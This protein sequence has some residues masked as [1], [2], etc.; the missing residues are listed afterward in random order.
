[1]RESVTLA[2]PNAGGTAEPPPAERPVATG[3]HGHL[4]HAESHP[5]AWLRVPARAAC[6][7]VAVGVG[8]GSAM[9]LPVAFGLLPGD[10]VPKAALWGA[11]GAGWAALTYRM[12]RALGNRKPF[13]AGQL[14]AAVLVVPGMS[15]LIGWDNAAV[16]PWAFWGTVAMFT[17]LIGLLLRNAWGVSLPAFIVVEEGRSD[18]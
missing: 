2:A 8:F 14:H 13:L 12:L 15:A 11:L 17:G 7:G 1:V 10:A 16:D 9:A 18:E 4:A 6:I 5:P 3:I